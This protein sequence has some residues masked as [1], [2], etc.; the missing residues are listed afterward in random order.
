MG[1]ISPLLKVFSEHLRNNKD[2]II[3]VIIISSIVLS[4]AMLSYYPRMEMY[5][6]Y[7]APYTDS[8][9]DVIVQD[10]NTIGNLISLYHNWLGVR[11]TGPPDTS[12]I[13]TLTIQE[14]DRTF[15]VSRYAFVYIAKASVIS[16]SGTRSNASLVI[17]DKPED[18]DLLLVY[19][20]KRVLT[21]GTVIAQA[22][23]SA[24]FSKPGDNVIISNKSFLI[25][26]S[27]FISPLH[28]ADISG[29]PTYIILK[30]DLPDNVHYGIGGIVV[31]T[32]KACDQE[33]MPEILVRVV[34]DYLRTEG[35]N[36]SVSEGVKL[37]REHEVPLGVSIVCKDYIMQEDMKLYEEEYGFRTEWGAVM[38]AAL[39]AFIAY[40]AKVA[41]SDVAERM[42]DLVALLYAVGAG[43]GQVAFILILQATIYILPAL[44]A[45]IVLTYFYMGHAMGF[46]FPFTLML[47]W[48]SPIIGGG[49]ILAIAL[50][51]IV[52]LYAV[53]RRPLSEILS[54][55]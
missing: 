8:D 40:I 43:D 26:D 30:D 7:F 54:G 49:V 5:Y 21:R 35:I 39:A 25:V 51:V 19:G 20:E 11:D 6:Q 53:R 52:G 29:S 31:D 50:S 41:Y 22:I 32:V 10:V 23:A 33:K 37:A 46:Y 13:A 36:I 14:L 1:N 15:G 9:A 24:E 44:L 18:L 3:K 34:V 27:A 45:G 55:A 42:R 38:L 16:E 12:L 17:V 47:Y 2:F 28:G 4:Y 48:F